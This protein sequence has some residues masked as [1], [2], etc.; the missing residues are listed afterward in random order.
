MHKKFFDQATIPK[1]GINIFYQN[2]LE[3][4]KIK[5]GIILDYRCSLGHNGDS[6]KARGNFYYIGA[7]HNLLSL[8]IG[9]L[10]FPSLDSFYHVDSIGGRSLNDIEDG[11]V[12]L[13]IMS[14]VNNYKNI[15]DLLP[16]FTRV[17]KLGGCLYIES[18]ESRGTPKLEERKFMVQY[19]KNNFKVTKL[20]N[21]TTNSCALNLDDLLIQSDDKFKY[22]LSGCFQR[23]E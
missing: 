4:S 21:N 19:L 2:A 11:T 9:S 15:E 1:D 18:H 17:L 22:K 10:K 5:S 8:M 20:L 6:L 7:D 14:L 12:D 16:E 3:L 13:I 23:K